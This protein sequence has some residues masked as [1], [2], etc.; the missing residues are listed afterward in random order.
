LVGLFGLWA[1]EKGAYVSPVMLR[2]RT[3]WTRPLPQPLHIVD[4]NKPLL[5]L[6]TVGDVRA[7]IVQHLPE[8]SRQKSI[9]K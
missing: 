4:G 7:L 6:A 5:T 2:K 8:E 1:V 9:W 3:D